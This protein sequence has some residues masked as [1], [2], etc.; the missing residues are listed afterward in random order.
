MKRT[1]RSYTVSIL[2]TFGLVACLVSTAAAGLLLLADFDDETVGQPIPWGGAAAGE[3][4]AIYPNQHVAAIVR[5]RPFPTPCLAISDTADVYVVDVVKFELLDGAE[6]THGIARVDM[7]LWIEQDN[8]FRVDVREH[9][10]ATYIFCEIALYDGLI[11]V[12]WE[13]AGHWVIGSY[14]TGEPFHLRL[15]WDMD[16]MTFT[17]K[18]DGSVLVDHVPLPP[19]SLGVG[20]VLVGSEAD[21]DATGT[22]Y[23]DNLTVWQDPPVGNAAATW[24]AVKNLYR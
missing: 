20:S 10:G 11:H 19:T 3:P 14:R 12:T 8:R 5:D 13:D 24:S 6:I 4:V 16:A 7:D 2:L 22:I 23:L 17:V 21:H 18:V 9:G 1:T 15:Q